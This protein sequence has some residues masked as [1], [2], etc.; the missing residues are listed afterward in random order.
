[1]HDFIGGESHTPQALERLVPALQQQGF[2]LVTLS[3]L[4]GTN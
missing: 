4:V 1:M 2:S 3:E